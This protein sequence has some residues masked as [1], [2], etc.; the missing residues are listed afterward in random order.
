MNALRILLPPRSF[1]VRDQD[2]RLFCSLTSSNSA[3]TLLEVM[4]SGARSRWKKDHTISWHCGFIHGRIKLITGA[5]TAIGRRACTH[6]STIWYAGCNLETNCNS[7]MLM[8]LCLL[9]LEFFC[10]RF[11][12][13]DHTSRLPEAHDTSLL[14]FS[15]YK[16]LGISQSYGLFEADSNMGFA[17]NSWSGRDDVVADVIFSLAVPDMLSRD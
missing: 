17:R 3:L 12:P 1:G 9:V 10:G 11:R 15:V 13:L 14:F 2:S 6:I 5:K 8:V 4:C 7:G 16:L